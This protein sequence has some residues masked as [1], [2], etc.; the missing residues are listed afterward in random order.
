MKNILFV[1]NNMEIGGTRRSLLNLLE[2]L[3]KRN[4]VKCDLLI[5]SPFG[6]YMDKIPNNIN[7][8]PSN[9]SL[10]AMF[11][12]ASALKQNKKYILYILKILLAAVKKCAGAA[13]IMNKLYKHHQKS[14]NTNYNM[15]I[16]FQEGE[17]NDYVS[18]IPADKRIFWIHNNYENL[19]DTAHGQRKSYDAADSVNFVAEA[20]M[21]SFADAMPEYAEKMR[22]IKNVLPQ[23]SIRTLSLEKCEDIFSGKGIKMISVGR[24]ANQKGF[25]RLVDVAERLKNKGYS[26]EWI[27]LGDGEQ[28]QTLQ[29]TV[30]RKGLE[31]YVKFV[32]SKPNPYPYIR[33]AD[34]F[35]LTSRY[36]SQPMVLMEALTIGTPVLSTS[37]D[38]VNEIVNGKDYAITVENNTEGIFEGL[39]KIIKDDK[40]L[41]SLKQATKDFSYDNQEIVDSILAL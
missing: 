21:K 2:V 14:L 12:S 25:D 34:L 5:F 38:S 29:E 4:N 33:Q 27:I 15:A 40:K 28:R 31:Q 13:N 30:F 32:G 16:G 37:F 36:E 17:C 22:V 11:T 24:V 20:S 35:V 7:I 1:I 41:S 23:D 39:D 26:F 6:E 19:S 9:K 8:I 10:E 3:S 18:M